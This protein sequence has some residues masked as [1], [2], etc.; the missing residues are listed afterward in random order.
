MEQ[1]PIDIIVNILVYQVL[2]FSKTQNY[3]FI[4]KVSGNVTVIIKSNYLIFL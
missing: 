1:I 4:G 2:T 3:F